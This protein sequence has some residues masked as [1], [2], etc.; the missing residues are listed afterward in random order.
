MN[1]MYIGKGH[2][3]DEI[4]N[5]EVLTILPRQSIINKNSIFVY[6]F[7]LS[8]LWHSQLRYMTYKSLSKLM[9][10]SLILVLTIGPNHNYEVCVEAKFAK[11]LFHSV[12]RITS[13]LELIHNDICDMK[14]VQTKSGK[15][16][17]FTFI[18]DCTR[19]YY[20]FLV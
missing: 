16:Y 18:D 14:S 1:E 19:Y 5:I 10:Q 7:E 9:N 15:K 17:F 4:F 3:C 8:C 13:P 6:M 11:T 2:I 12:Q 20:V